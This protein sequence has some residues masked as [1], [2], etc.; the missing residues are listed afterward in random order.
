[1]KYVEPI[2]EKVWIKEFARYFE[3]RNQRGYV[4]FMTGIH[5]GLRISDI[6]PLRKCD[7]EGT[8][9]MIK[10]KRQ[11]NINGYSYPNFKKYLPTIVL[12]WN[13]LTYYFQVELNQKLEKLNLW[14]YNCI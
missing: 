13:A 2:R 9:L 12:T 5:M 10:E 3:S 14:S 11:E 8:H 1:M 7:I 6:L 4:L